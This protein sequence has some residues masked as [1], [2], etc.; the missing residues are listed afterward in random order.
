MA[1]AEPES[2]HGLRHLVEEGTRAARR[3]PLSDLR[4]R[5]R[6]RRTFREVATVTAV[7]AAVV[8]VFPLV[9]SFDRSGTSVPGPT[10]PHTPQSAPPSLVATPTQTVPG[11]TITLTGAGCAPGTSVSFGI[12]WDRG[13]KLSL[14]MEE[15]KTS[16][17][18]PQTT[19][20]AAGSHQLASVDA[21]ATGSFEATVTIPTS[22]AINK[23]TLWARCRTA[24]PS[25]QLTQHVSIVVR[26]PN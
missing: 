9:A 8:A 7:A 6:R 15:Q 2:E 19:A 26:S 22:P 18:Q 23:P 13:A 11:G 24:A 3:P 4:R 10:A 5:A 25:R 14:S 17:G 21:L 12:R 20:T 1:D 16:P